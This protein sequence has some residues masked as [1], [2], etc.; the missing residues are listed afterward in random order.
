VGVAERDW[1]R[2]EPPGTQRSRRK[3]HAVGLL[4]F[5]VLA[6]ALLSQALRQGAPADPEHAVHRDLSFGFAPGLTVRIKRA[7]LYAPND[8]WKSYL[9]DEQTCPHAEDLSAPLHEQALTMICLINHARR[10]RGLTELAVL[11][12]LSEAARLKGEEIGRCK[13]FA[14]APCGGDARDVA[15]QA[16]FGGR[17]GENIYIAEGRYG[18]PRPA[19]DGWLN[20]P[21]HRENLFS[22]LWNVQSVYVVKLDVFPGFKTPMLW[23]SEFGG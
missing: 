4:V 5:F 16:G 13:V 21:G 20:S 10:G 18:A 15:I 1:Y 19:L 22:P 9:A 12:Q 8:P 11:P 3:W 7:P 6:L 23:V 17:W 2:E 14:H